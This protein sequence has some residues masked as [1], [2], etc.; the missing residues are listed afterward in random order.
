MKLRRLAVCIALGTM[1]GSAPARAQDT[2]FD[3]NRF[4]VQGNTLLLPGQVE[5]LLAPY[6]G[7]GRVYGDVQ[8]ALDALESAYRAKGYSTVNVHVPEQEITRGVIRL[9]VSEAVLGNLTINSG[10]FFDAANVRASLPNLKEGEAPNLR[11]ISENVQLINEN[12]AKQVEV[13]LATSEAEGK[14][15]AKVDLAEQ[16]P[17]RIYVSLDDTGTKETG[18]HRL[19]LAFQHANLLGGDE[20]LTLAYT[21]SPDVWMNH[22]DNTKVDVYSVAFRKPF[23]GIGD[24]L[25][26][27]YGNSNVNTP[28]AQA[29]GF[30]IVGKGEVVALRW[31]HL[32]PRRGEYSS[33]LVFGYDYKHINTTCDPDTSGTVPTCTPYTLQ[34]VSAVYN[35]Q[36]QGLGYQANY[37]LGLI[38]NL[39]AAGKTYTTAGRPNGERTNH[40]SFISG[41]DVTDNFLILR[42][43][44]SYTQQVSGWMLRGSA[45]GQAA[46]SGLPSAEQFG[47]VGATAV[48][49]FDERALAADTGIVI[50]LEAYTPNFADALNLPGSL[51]G[52]VF[53]DFGYGRNDDVYIDDDARKI[54]SN[55][56]N[57]T[58]VSSVGVGMRYA[59]Q[60]DV[61]FS[62]DVAKV[63]D[64]GTQEDFRAR[65]G[66]G[67]HFRLTL[68][69]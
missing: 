34:P 43:G 51:L 14:V 18:R 42:Y 40:Y 68:G 10:K 63:T 41:R 13:T 37:N 36:L 26:I 28:S 60:K 58:T 55:A 3:I 53:F 38:Y 59:L 7:K 35:G 39:H 5:E 49:G 46:T 69:F 66:W 32:F 4:D 23:Y 9:K 44:G 61:S 2:R 21:G 33:K 57:G 62:L 47:M 65:N 19:G 29:T 20:V 22:P 8:K 30:G 15:D 31:N 24:S 48:R 27:I 64:D 12:P 67:G 25:D 50:N 17:K 1:V 52:L 6:I 11:Q 56:F 54:S 16:D 45:N